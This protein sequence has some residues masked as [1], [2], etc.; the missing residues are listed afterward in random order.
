MTTAPFSKKNTPHHY[1]AMYKNGK[2]LPKTGD[3]PLFKDSFQSKK[4]FSRR[5]RLLLFD[6][7]HHTH[8]KDALKP[9][10]LAKK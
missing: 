8:Q 3:L 4:T 2:I 10:P 5:F 9:R 7:Q 6:L 1:Y